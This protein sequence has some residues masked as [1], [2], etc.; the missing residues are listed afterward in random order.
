MAKL[1]KDKKIKELEA[2]I[3]EITNLATIYLNTNKRLQ[4]EN[5]NLLQ[6]KYFCIQHWQKFGLEKHV[7][8]VRE[9]TKLFN[10]R[11]VVTG[12]DIFPERKELELK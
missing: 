4:S 8:I 10:Y 6:F 3:S 7:Y 5:E 1:T 12:Y 2:K 9:F 11:P